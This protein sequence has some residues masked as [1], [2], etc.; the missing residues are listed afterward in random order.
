[1]EPS[2]TNQQKLFR[3]KSINFSPVEARGRYYRHLVLVGLWLHFRHL[4]WQIS[5]IYKAAEIFHLISPLLT[6][7]TKL[8]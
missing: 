2:G 4:K 5:K 3:Y 8:L 7:F 1:M 6:Q